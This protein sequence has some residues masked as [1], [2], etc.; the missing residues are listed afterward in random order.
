MAAAESGMKKKMKNNKEQ[1]EDKKKPGACKK[2]GGA[3]FYGDVA[4]AMGCDGISAD[5][6]QNVLESIRKATIR[7]E[8]K[9]KQFKLANMEMLQLRHIIQ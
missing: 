1:I 7:E 8:Q 6:V 5:I 9:Q 2:G 4:E 3:S